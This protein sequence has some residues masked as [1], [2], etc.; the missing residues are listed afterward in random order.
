MWENA[1]SGSAFLH[2]PKA[3]GSSVKNG[4]RSAGVVTLDYSALEA[5]HR[6][7]CTCGDP[8]C[9]YAIAVENSF[10]REVSTHRPWVVDLGHLR[11]T[12]DAVAD[13]PPGLPIVVPLRPPPD[14][15]VSLFLFNWTQYVYARRMRVVLSRRLTLA[16]NPRQRNRRGRRIFWGD[17]DRSEVRSLV[18]DV[19]QLGAY[20]ADD[21]CSVLWRD[22]AAAA[23]VSGG[24]PLFWYTDLLPDLTGERDPRWGRLTPVPMERL[25]IWLEREFGAVMPHVNR[26]IDR[27]EDLGVSAAA[28][29]LRMVAA[30]YAAVDQRVWDQLQVRF[31]ELP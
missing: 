9:R 24:G 21:G 26:S 4:L 12:A 17:A 18:A 1:F 19:P 7:G 22:W 15:V 20:V 16:W 30:E 3:A 14:R 28:D 13:L 27:F 8:V 10:L 11:L 5:A 6:T 2:V 29:E 31:R 25:S 23:L